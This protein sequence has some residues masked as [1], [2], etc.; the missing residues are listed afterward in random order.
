M[1]TGIEQ[2][3]LYTTWAPVVAL[4]IWKVLIPLVNLLIAKMDGTDTRANTRLNKI[5]TNDLTHIETRLKS[6]EDGMDAF[7]ERFGTIGERLAVLETLVNE[8]KK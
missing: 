7:R 6:I 1:N 8:V 3:L 2:T 5:E 4:F